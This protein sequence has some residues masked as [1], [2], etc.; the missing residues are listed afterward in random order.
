MKHKLKS[1]SMKRKDQDFLYYIMET[2]YEIM[3]KDNYSNF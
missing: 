1:L 2:T 3:S